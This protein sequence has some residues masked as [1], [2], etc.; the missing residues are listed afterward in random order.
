[1]LAEAGRAHHD[2]HPV[3]GVGGP[4]RSSPECLRPGD[5]AYTLEPSWANEDGPLYVSTPVEPE[6][7]AGCAERVGPTSGRFAMSDQ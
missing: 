7:N 3:R 2:D 6:C 4:R 1:M 5:A